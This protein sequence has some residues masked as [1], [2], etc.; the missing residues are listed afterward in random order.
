MFMKPWRIPATV[1]NEGKLEKTEVLNVY[2]Y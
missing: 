1:L 2:Q